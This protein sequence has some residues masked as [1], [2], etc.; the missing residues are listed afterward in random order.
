MSS[1]QLH[2]ALTHVPVILSLVGLVMLATAFFN[3]NP[4]IVKISY[5][6]ILIA[7]IAA[8]PV[9]FTGEGAEE[10]VEN[11]PGVAAQAIEEHEEIAKFAMI[12]IAI[13][14]L[15][16]L[17][18][19]VFKKR[20]SFAPYFKVIVLTLAIISGGLMV[21]TAQLGGKI[22]HTELNGNIATQD[23]GSSSQEKEKDDD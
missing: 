11:L 6:I 14:G 23:M 3:R 1:V 5:V 12:F 19:L 22:R 4:A 20:L 2:L 7:G 16:A 10:A 8:T 13:A 18:A 15:A 21:R 9:F 17:A